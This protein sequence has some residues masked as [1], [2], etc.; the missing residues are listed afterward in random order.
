MKDQCKKHT[1]GTGFSCVYFMGIIGAA[2]YFI[3]NATGFW[4]GVG[5]FFKALV[6]PAIFV[7]QGFMQLGI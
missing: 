4:M 7:Y 5:G 6:W 3:S 1:S 2:V